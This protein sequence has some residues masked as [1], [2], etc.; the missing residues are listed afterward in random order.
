MFMKTR[1]D[2]CQRLILQTDPLSLEGM[3]RGLFIQYFFHI[4]DKNAI[5]I[6]SSNL[7][8]PR[9]ITC[10]TPTVFKGKG[11]IRVTPGTV[12]GVAQSP[13]AYACNYVEARTESST[14]EIGEGTYINN[15]ATIVSEGAS[16]KIGNRCLIG[17]EFVILDANGHEMEV[18]RRYSPDQNPRPV[19]I[20][21]DVFIGI[22]VTILKGCRI[23]SGSVIAAGS[24]LQPYFEAPPFSKIAGN[25]ARIVG[26]LLKENSI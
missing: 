16:I 2:D 14:I 22:R 10:I 24:V 8:A 13:G 7:S 3:V 21:D 9:V 23:G 20:G 5:E 26:S 4:S 17:P 1:I 15:R 25:P 18:S 6:V 19:E 12:F 11:K